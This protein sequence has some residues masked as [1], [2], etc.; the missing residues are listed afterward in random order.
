[1]QTCLGCLWQL[2]GDIKPLTWFR[3][4][5]VRE[6]SSNLLPQNAK[7]VE[8]VKEIAK[9]KGATPGQIALAWVLAQG[10]DVFP[11]PGELVVPSFELSVLLWQTF[12]FQELP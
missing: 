5:D 3:H 8:T 9:A 4:R 1:M 7:P 12:P 6:D 2:R 11:I 10:N